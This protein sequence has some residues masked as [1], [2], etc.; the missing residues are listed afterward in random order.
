M[1]KDFDIIYGL[2]L[3]GIQKKKQYYNDDNKIRDR[4]NKFKRSYQII[5]PGS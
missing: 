1:S 2:R 5:E 3:N 4:F